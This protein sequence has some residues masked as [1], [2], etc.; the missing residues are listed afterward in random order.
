MISFING[1]D[2][3]S[4]IPNV[5]DTVV[6]DNNAFYVTRVGEKSIR[7]LFYW[8]NLAYVF[9]VM[10]R[11]NIMDF[12]LNLDISLKGETRGLFGNF[13]DDDTD[14]FIQPNGITVPSDGITDQMLHEFGQSCEL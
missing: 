10:Q 13:N 1:E 6:G 14:D 11:E 8:D 12:I 5:N 2:V 3:S 4:N 7:M 9:T